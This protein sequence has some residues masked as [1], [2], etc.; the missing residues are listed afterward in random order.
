VI[1]RKKFIP[2]KS[3]CYTAPPWL[4]WTTTWQ[5]VGAI[6]LGADPLSYRMS[7]LHD[8]SLPAPFRNCRQAQ[9]HARPTPPC[10][11]APDHATPPRCPHGSP[12][13]PSA[14]LRHLLLPRPRPPPPVIVA[15]ILRPN[16]LALLLVLVDDLRACIGVIPN[17]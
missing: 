8:F 17:L 5:G 9:P 16:A 13:V 2:P 11:P 15:D 4:T 1:N 14:A 12:V 3:V 6:D 10:R 7:F